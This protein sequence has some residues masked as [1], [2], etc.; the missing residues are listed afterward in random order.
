MK[1]KTNQAGMSRRSAIQSVLGVAG[2]S[3]MALP[4]ASYAAPVMRDPIVR[5][6]V[7]R[8]A[9]QRDPVKITKLENLPGQ[10]ALDLP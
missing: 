9:A 7:M 3:M 2:A 4:R 6:P 1:R 10:A 5:D 8:I